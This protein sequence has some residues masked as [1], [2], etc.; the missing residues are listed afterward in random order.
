MSTPKPAVQ[1]PGWFILPP[2]KREDR[3]KVACRRLERFGF[4]P[5]RDQVK[6][7]WLVYIPLERKSTPSQMQ[8]DLAVSCPDVVRG[9]Q[10]VWP[11]GQMQSFEVAP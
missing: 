11:D 2:F 1:S 4:R 6:D 8:R 3:A 10:F 9:A 5:R 7:Q